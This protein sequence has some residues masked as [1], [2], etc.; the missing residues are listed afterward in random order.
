M[1]ESL[2]S[3]RVFLYESMRDAT[4]LTQ[5]LGSMTLT[6][7]CKLPLLTTKRKCVSFDTSPRGIRPNSDQATQQP[8]I[9]CGY[10]K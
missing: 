6:A 7:S 4:P 2:G 3:D 1:V 9:L 8:M 10:G 5:S